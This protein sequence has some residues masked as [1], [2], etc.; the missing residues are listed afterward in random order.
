[1]SFTKA[2]NIRKYQQAKKE[3]NSVSPTRNGGC[4]HF[5]A[6]ILLFIITVRFGSLIHSFKNILQCLV[7][8]AII[9]GRGWMST[10]G[11][12]QTARQCGR[13]LFGGHRD[14]VGGS[15]SSKEGPRIQTGK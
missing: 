11:G 1:M 8:R 15:G 4:Q 9:R 6:L 2:I 12:I 10:G 7:I 5:V 14:R 3:Y 13:V